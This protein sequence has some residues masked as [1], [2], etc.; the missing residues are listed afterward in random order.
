MRTGRIRGSLVWGFQS[1]A[2]SIGIVLHPCSARWR[3]SG[4][5][6]FVVTIDAFQYSGELAN[7]C[8]DRTATLYSVR[9]ARD[10]DHEAAIR[11]EGE[12]EAAGTFF[13][14]HC[15]HGIPRVTATPES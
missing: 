9:S 2:C 3:S 5:G 12:S 8:Y 1:Q 13:P 11:F 6:V 4:S 14:R 15:S 10:L 7:G